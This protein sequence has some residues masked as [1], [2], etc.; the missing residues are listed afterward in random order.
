MNNIGNTFLYIKL[1]VIYRSSAVVFHKTPVAV[2]VGS[3]PESQLLLSGML[4]VPVLCTT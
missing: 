4:V 2:P 3:V 1:L